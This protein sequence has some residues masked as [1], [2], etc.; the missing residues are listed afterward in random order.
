MSV[1]VTVLTCIFLRLSG[2]KSD[3]ETP[4]QAEQ[5]Y[6]WCTLH[7]LQQY[8]GVSLMH[9]TSQRWRRV[10]QAGSNPK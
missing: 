9:P 1:P 10:G 2:A 7:I 8:L 3:S 6:I 4:S 5:V